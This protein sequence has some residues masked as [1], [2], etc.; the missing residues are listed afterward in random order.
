MYV[1][2]DFSLVEPIQKKSDIHVYTCGGIILI[3][4]KPIQYYKVISLQ[5]K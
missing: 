1:T 5:L 2:N 3:Y 4:G